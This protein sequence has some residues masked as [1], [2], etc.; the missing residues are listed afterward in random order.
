MTRT[1]ASPS[2]TATVAH[3]L[4]AC[5]I[6][7]VV[8]I[9]P[10][11]AADGGGDTWH[12]LSLE[13]LTFEMAEQRGLFV[14]GVR[15]SGVR[16][17]SPASRDF[18]VEDVITYANRKPVRT[19]E[20]LLGLLYGVKDGERIALVRVRKDAAT[21][22]ITLDRAGAPAEAPEDLLASAP[23]LM[24]DT[25][26]HMSIINDVVFTPDG[27]QVVSAADD[28]VIRVWDV[29]TGRTLRTMRG[30]L[31]P[32]EPGKVFAMAMSPDGRWLAA[33]GWMQN[34]MVAPCCGDI[35]I[36]DFASGTLV[37]RLRAHTSV[38]FGLSFS[39]DGRKLISSS[40]DNS[41]IVW[42]APTSDTDNADWSRGYKVHKLEGH[43]ERIYSVRFLP[44]GKRA[45]SSSYDK[46][47]RVWDLETGD[48]AGIMTGHPEGVR[49]LSVAPDGSIA[50]G[51]R[52]GEVRIWDAAVVAGLK[53]GETTRRSR[54]LTNQ[55]GLVGR[56][57]F[58]PDG[59]KL[60]STCGYTGCR[61]TQIVLDSLTGETLARFRKHDDIVLASNWSRD[62]K[63]IT[64]A[65][66]NDRSVR[67]WSP[68]TGKEVTDADG[69][70]IVYRGGGR[71]VWSAAMSRDGKWIGWGFRW[72]RRSATARGPVQYALK[73]PL[74][75]EA[76]GQ[77]IK[78]DE[79]VD[80][81][82]TVGAD[83]ASDDFWYRGTIEANGLKLSHRKGGFFGYDALLDIKAGDEVRATIE[84]GRTNG[85]QHRSY[86]FVPGER[87]LISGGANGWLARF[88]IDGKR[89]GNFVGHENELW[90]ATPSADGRFLISGSADQTVRLWNMKTRELLVT[91]FHAPEAGD[92]VMWTPQGF[93]TGSENAGRYVGWQI[94]NGPDTAA[95]YVTGGQFRRA[96]ARPDIIEEAIRRG[97]AKAAVAALAPDHDLSKIL[98]RRPPELTLVTPDAYSNEFRGSKIVTAFMKQGSFPTDRYEISVN[99]IAVPTQWAEVPVDHPRPPPGQE[100]VA[101]RVPLGQ[102][103][104]DVT[105]TAVSR[106]ASV[107]RLASAPLQLR[108]FHNGEGPLDTRDTLHIVAIGVN[109]YDGLGSSCG[110]N[111]R[112]SCNLTYAGKDAL[113]LADTVAKTLGPRHN[114]GVRMRVLASG[115][116]FANR[117]TRSNILAALDELSNAGLNDTVVVFLAGH[118]EAARVTDAEGRTQLNYYFL[119]TDI[120]RAGG[121]QAA[122][123]GENIIEWSEIQS[124][125][126][127]AEGRRVLFLDS[128]QSAAVGAG[129]AYNRALIE[130]ASYDRFAAFMAAGPNQAAYELPNVGQGLFTHAIAEGLLG[131]AASDDETVVRVKALGDYIEDVVRRLS[132]GRQSPVYSTHADFVLAAK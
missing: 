103:A 42:Q 64:T 19:A 28:K 4:I 22:K 80:Y 86:A 21:A 37:T 99:G 26:G 82:S 74:D 62:G 123:T 63:W 24:L 23:V 15:V 20:D 66:G 3:L 95:G 78:V 31:A 104:N 58:S 30:E 85:F 44:G 11:R 109:D 39:A 128:C 98:S 83:L 46:T 2:L 10:A 9:A 113:L 32:G 50:S 120:R 106:A 94:N 29:A 65:G 96:L 56:L 116:G 52:G 125:L 79:K 41:V 54:Y 101:F 8:L 97:S 14:E 73:L 132:Q 126:K 114:R 102:G 87:A 121:F 112:Q 92:W 6:A 90:A 122:G 84:L 49:S 100:V 124:R 16:D 115:T 110:S 34:K 33:G 43:T 127:R 38:V 70:P 35:R 60:L 89:Q 67:V 59:Q 81:T 25:G 47:I 88:G 71:T 117:P 68:D 1:A 5:A 131:E 69:N 77:L 55:G 129:R 36:Y 108:V 40:S 53:N 45:V 57:E 107:D 13:T 27:K 119:P 72:Q 105:I 75:G 61:D 130:D 93:Y 48:L 18:K 118:G 12:G 111:G 7:I 91:V 51:D 17:D 76:I